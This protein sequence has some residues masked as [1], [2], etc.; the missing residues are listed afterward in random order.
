H[1]AEPT[2][3]YREIARVLKPGG[4]FCFKTPAVHTPLFFCSRLL[5]T[6]W[7][8]RLKRRIGTPEADVFPTYY[9]ANTPGR[10]DRDLTRLGFRR[11]WLTRVDQ[12]YAYLS[13]T[14]GSYAL[15]L[16][17]SRLTELR[18]LRWLRNQILGIYQWQAPTPPPAS[19][20][21]G[22]P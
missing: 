10:L 12:T 19:S 16:I 14:R 13:Q 5:P 6:A 15:G 7:H 17:Y 22:T 8:R 11:D 21:E 4:Y 18:P 2:A 9:R 20:W 3:A 1:L